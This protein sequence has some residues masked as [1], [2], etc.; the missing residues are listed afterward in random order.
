VEEENVFQKGNPLPHRRP[1]PW[2]IADVSAMPNRFLSNAM[3]RE[4]FGL[5]RFSLER[6]PSLRGRFRNH[7]RIH[8]RSDHWWCDVRSVREDSGFA[9]VVAAAAFTRANP[10]RDLPFSTLARSK[11]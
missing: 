6:F 3:V 4:H 1:A 2:R 5:S 9:A 7:D 10:L 11:P 8:R